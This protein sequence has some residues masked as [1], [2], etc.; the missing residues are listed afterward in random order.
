MVTTDSG[1]PC[2]LCDPFPMGALC[3]WMIFISLFLNFGLQ[4]EFP[5][6]SD[7]FQGIGLGKGTWDTAARV[8]NPTIPKQVLNW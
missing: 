6:F 2:F 7:L 1:V 3:K 5:F 4:G 8:F